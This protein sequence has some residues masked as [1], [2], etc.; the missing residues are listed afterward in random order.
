M[1]G[2]ANTATGAEYVHKCQ[3]SLLPPKARCHPD[4]CLACSLSAGLIFSPS[5]LP[6]NQL[7][8]NSFL[9]PG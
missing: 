6:L 5:L 1:K 4:A 7:L 9:L 2:F 3:L 8:I